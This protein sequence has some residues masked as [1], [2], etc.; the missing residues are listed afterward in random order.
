MAWKTLPLTDGLYEN[1]DAEELPSTELA[2]KLEN[3]IMNEAGSNID[4]PALSL[5]A[6]VEARKVIGMH[7]WKQEDILVFVTDDRRIWTVTEA[8]VTAEI[9]GAAVLGGTERVSFAEDGILLA[10]AGGGAPQ[11]WAGT[12]TCA[13]MGGAP[14]NTKSIVYLD[15]Y[16]IAATID[17]QII[18]WA[19]PTAVTRATWS[20]GN[21]FSA[22]AYPDNVSALHVLFRELWSL[23]D[24]S[25]EVYQNL[26][27]STVPFQRVFAFDRGIGATFSVIQADNTLW[28][29]DSERR[30][31]RMNGKTPEI[32][33]GPIS[34]TLKAMTTVSDCWGA[35]IDID[36][37]FLLLWSFPTEE[38]TYVYDY[39]NKRWYRWYTY[40]DTNE[41]HFAVGAHAFAKTWN[42]HYVGGAYSGIVSELSRSF[43]TDN[44]DPL[45]RVRRTGW[46]D[47]GTGTRKRSNGYRFS[48]KRGLGTPGETEPLFEFRFNDDG[49]GWCDPI[50]VGLGFPGE[51]TSHIFVPIRGIY[52]KRQF[53]VTCS[54][55]VEFMLTKAEED[56]EA[57][58]S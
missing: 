50:E 17:D 37:Y 15:G 55:A 49:E 10:L 43:K 24:E 42:K 51:P 29:F 21:F 26:G 9:T 5:F 22:E 48:V 36:G 46:I 19:G 54:A 18:Q 38:K 6:T 2:V 47:H 44:A 40:H 25:I 13:V 11:S 27:T 32:I 56:V 28:F 23:G 39:L 30:F 53:E 4:R 12:G 3:L 45:R 7:F 14:P 31:I 35:R 16:W 1:V 41:V 34:R 8:G 33:S 52:R 58:V 20:A 57:L